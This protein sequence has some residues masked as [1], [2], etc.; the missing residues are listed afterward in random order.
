MLAARPAL[1]A[2]LVDEVGLGGDQGAERD[3]TRPRTLGPWATTRP[4]ISWPKIR[5]RPLPSRFWAQSSQL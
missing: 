4:A 3:L 2:A 1:V 5:G